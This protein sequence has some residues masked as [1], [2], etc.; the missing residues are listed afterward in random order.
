MIGRS[1]AAFRGSNKS[2]RLPFDL[3]GELKKVKAPR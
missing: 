2:K 1:V 3:T